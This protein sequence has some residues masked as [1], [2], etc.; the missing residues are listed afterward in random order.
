MLK[1]KPTNNINW[2]QAITSSMSA[3]IPC[4]HKGLSEPYRTT[5][6][7]TTASN[8]LLNST[9]VQVEMVL[10][11]NHQESGRRNKGVQETRHY[12]PPLSRGPQTRQAPNRRGVGG[13]SVLQSQ[14]ARKNTAFTRPCLPAALCQ[15]T[16]RCVQ[17][18]SAVTLQLAPIPK[19]PPALWKYQGLNGFWPRVSPWRWG[20]STWLTHP[21][22]S[23]PSTTK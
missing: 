12:Q 3:A 19:P 9:S 14:A 10:C 6:P 7:H 4:S 5:E 13:R 2:D 18:L 1:H 20:G 23:R 16:A 21:R 17:R 15:W 22:P 8:K 11:N